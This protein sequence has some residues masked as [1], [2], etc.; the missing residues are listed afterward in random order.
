ML[1]FLER[2]AG[3][4]DHLN[5][6][7][8]RIVAW[9]TLAMVLVTFAVVVL[10]YG[11]SLGSIA[12]QES[13]SYMHALVFMLAAAYTYRHDEHVRVDIVYRRL[14]E[15]GR[16][17]VDLGGTLFL[18]LPVMGFI[19]WSS[20]DYVTAAWGLR[21]GS[22]EAGGLPFVYLLKTA[23][24]VMPALFALQGLATICRCISMLAR[25]GRSGEAV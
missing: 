11:F 21:E 23:L 24:V 19:F 18:L 10:R 25:T 14:S 1:A 12:I 6:T 13:V 17:W 7:V 8:G 5:E 9:L 4:I 20:L 16:A 3:A 15:R 2:L 22:R